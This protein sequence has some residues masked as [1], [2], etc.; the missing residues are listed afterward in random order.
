[1]IEEKISEILGIKMDSLVKRI[2]DESNN[3]KLIYHGIKRPKYIEP[4]LYEGIKPLTPEGG[5]CSFW[6][7]GTAVFYPSTDSVL[8]DWSGNCVTDEKTELNIAIASYDKLSEELGKEFLSS[9]EKDS[10]IRIYK[11]VPKLS[12]NLLSVGLNHPKAADIPEGRNY[13]QIAERVMVV[14]LLAHMGLLD[15]ESIKSL[16]IKE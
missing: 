13:R 2:I 8:F 9:Y 1:M 7:T 4:I 16:E 11:T 14:G 15:S 12:F 10:Q 6:A 3:K 5:D